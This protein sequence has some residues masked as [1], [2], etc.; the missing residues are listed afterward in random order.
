MI[1][2][3]YTFL[4]RKAG[5]E[6]TIAETADDPRLRELATKMSR[7]L[8]AVLKIHRPDSTSGRYIICLGCPLD[9]RDP[10][11]Y[12]DDCRI[13]GDIAEIYLEGS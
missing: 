3:A 4:S 7:V 13:L 2:N 1:D 9:P 5:E 8:S 12:I 11:P 6:A 10:G